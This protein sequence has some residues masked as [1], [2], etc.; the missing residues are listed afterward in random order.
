VARDAVESRALAKLAFGVTGHRL[1][2]VA[3]FDRSR[4]LAE[5]PLVDPRKNHWI[6]V[7]EAAE[8][9]SRNGSQVAVGL[10]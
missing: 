8:H 9:D 5:E 6:V 2:D 10:L 3:E 7:G 4:R 1:H